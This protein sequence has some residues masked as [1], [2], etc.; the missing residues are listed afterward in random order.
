MLQ[1]PPLSTKMK[2]TGKIMKFDYTGLRYRIS[3]MFNSIAEFAEKM[4]VSEKH[5]T[6]VLNNKK[7]FSQEEINKVCD[8]LLIPY[9]FIDIFFFDV[10]GRFSTN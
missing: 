6:D 5:I 10:D 7:Y 8:I 2:G 4:N 1:H 3:L 9:E